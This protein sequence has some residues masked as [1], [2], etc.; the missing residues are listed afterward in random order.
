MVKI[1]TT[2]KIKYSE[3]QG[4][5]NEIMFYMQETY[6]GD[7]QF[8]VA[9]IFRNAFLVSVITNNSEIW[10]NVTNSELLKLEALDAQLI[11]RLLETNSKT[12]ICIMMLELGIIPLRFTIK[13]K[14]LSYFHHLLTSDSESLARK[15]LMK[16]IKKPKPGDWIKLVESDLKEIG[17]LQSYE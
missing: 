13:M 8:E 17:I 6:Y 9:K 15:V 11:R 7:F 3:G 2:F 14:R 4:V 1:F 16:Q 10:H 5:V 12:S